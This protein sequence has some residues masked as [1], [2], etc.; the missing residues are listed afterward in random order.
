MPTPPRHRC[1]RW[2][3]R[4][5]PWRAVA[6]SSTVSG[7]RAVPSTAGA[8]DAVAFVELVD[9][10]FGSNFSTAACELLFAERAERTKTCAK[11]DFKNVAEH[12]MSYLSN[13]RMYDLVPFSIFSGFTLLIMI[14]ASRRWDFFNDGAVHTGSVGEFDDDADSSEGVRSESRRS[15]RLT[16]WSDKHS[17]SEGYTIIDVI[18]IG[19]ASCRERV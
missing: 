9:A 14:Y 10:A 17:P 2:L 12:A 19:R 18:E 6:C 13:R 16:P 1:G 11:S 8:S 5:G 7:R 3:H 4:V 15:T